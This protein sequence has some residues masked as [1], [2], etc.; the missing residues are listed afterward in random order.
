M[1]HLKMFE[2]KE[3]KLY[4]EQDIRDAIEHGLY[5][6]DDFDRTSNYDEESRAEGLKEIQDEYID[7]LNKK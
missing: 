1:K 7:S 2:Y 6:Y 5:S 4:T 3:E